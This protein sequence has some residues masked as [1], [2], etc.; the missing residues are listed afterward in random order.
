MKDSRFQIL[1]RLLVT[2]SINVQPGEKVLV[3]NTD[4]PTEFTV[5]LIEA[6]GE[7]G[8]LSLVITH[9]Q[10]VLRSL[11][12]N[13]TEEQMKT[14]GDI[15]TVRMEAVQCYIAVRGTYNSS[16]YSDL[17]GDNMA[18]YEKQWWHR[19]HSK[20][21]VP[22]TKWVVLRWPH[23]SMAQSAGMSTEAFEDFYFR[24]CGGVDYKQME[25]AVEPL[26]QL[27]ASTD[28]VRIT[29]P[30]TDLSF[31]IKGIGAIPCTGHRNIPDGECFTAPV[32]DSV[33][34]TLQYNCDTVYRGTVFSGVRFRFANGKIIEADAGGNTAKLNAL[35]DSDEG[36]RYIGEWSL[37]FNPF[38]T[39]PMRDTLFDEKIAGS[40]HMTPGNAYDI[41]DNGNK[42]QIHWDMVC[43][44]DAK[45]GGGKI[46]F[47]DVLI[48]ENGIFTLPELQSLNPESFGG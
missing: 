11:I 40:F 43:L 34:G 37:G 16:E 6:I 12:K 7:V 23:P 45:N 46:Y 3:E 24:V 15:E 42:S 13:A 2:H 17:P 10:Q 28:R 26:Q 35:L 9:Q 8:G 1:A 31:S 21:R 19:V 33:N 22:K 38:V 25:R 41:A 30:G 44:Q 18:I 36:A 5:A 4:V 27:M 48:R 47:D 14:I 32:R 20:I 29:G 39:I